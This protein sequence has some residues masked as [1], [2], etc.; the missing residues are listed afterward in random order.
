MVDEDLRGPAE[1]FKK[2][3][4]NGKDFLA[5]ATPPELQADLRLAPFTAKKLLAV[6]DAYLN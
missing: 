4:V 1:D 6:R 2:A 5:W 3:G